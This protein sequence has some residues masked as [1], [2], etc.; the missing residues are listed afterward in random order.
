MAERLHSLG[1]F[2][3]HRNLSGAATVDSSTIN[4]TNFPI[5]GGFDAWGWETILLYFTGT[6]EDLAVHE[7]V[8][9]PLYRDAT[10]GTW[11][12]GARF[13]LKVRQMAEF[14]TNGAPLVF[15]RIEAVVGAGL[16][17]VQMRCSGGLASRR[18]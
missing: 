8:L 6:G 3:T 1:K 4:D 18:A 5:A 7:L 13:T 15:V 9:E 16:S 17:A 14:P 10:N 11:V 2:L 12:R